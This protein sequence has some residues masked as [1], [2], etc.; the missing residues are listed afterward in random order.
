MCIPLRIKE[1][2]WGLLY[3][4]NSNFPES[5]RGLSPDRLESIA[6]RLSRVLG[7]FYDFLQVN[8][9]RNRLALEKEVALE[10]LQIREF[11]TTDP[12]MQGILS[13]ADRAAASEAR[14]SGI[15]RNRRRQGASGPAHP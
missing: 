5:Y 12:V 4:D 9:D 13:Q 10:R 2:L 15:G 3:H 11:L 7:N 8:E 1:R 14:H 6:V